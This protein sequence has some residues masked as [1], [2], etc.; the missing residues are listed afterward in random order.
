MKL[1]YQQLFC[2]IADESALI[3]HRFPRLQRLIM[4]ISHD[5]RLDD[6]NEICSWSELDF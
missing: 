5:Y 1:R 6:S 2:A 3:R 4:I